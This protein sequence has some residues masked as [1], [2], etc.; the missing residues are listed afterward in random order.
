[1]PACRQLGYAAT[2]AMHFGQLIRSESKMRKPPDDPIDDESDPRRLDMSSLDAISAFGAARRRC[3]SLDGCR[4]PPCRH[5]GSDVRAR[6]IASAE[7]AQHGAAG[8]SDRRRPRPPPMDAGIRSSQ[9]R[10]SDCESFP[11]TATGCSRASPCSSE[12]TRTPPGRSGR[13]ARNRAADRRP[14]RLPDTRSA[15]PLGHGRCTTPES[16]MRRAASSTT[17]PNSASISA[18]RRALRALRAAVG[19]HSPHPYCPARRA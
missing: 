16:P 12:T 7:P 5:D 2:S 6:H 10:R 4:R 9:T 14:P 17:K 18:A 11:R 13:P 19:P 1:M 8:R 15:E 3:A